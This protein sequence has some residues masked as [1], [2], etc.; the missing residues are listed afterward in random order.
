M[1]KKW[2]VFEDRYFLEIM[3]FEEEL[4]IAELVE[5]DG[6]CFSSSLVNIQDEYLGS[7]SLEHAKEEVEIFIINQIMDEIDYNDHLLSVIN[8]EN[9]T[10]YHCPLCKK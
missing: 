9:D 5:D 6:W 3:L 10:L 1:S 4:I 2:S 8:D 7:D